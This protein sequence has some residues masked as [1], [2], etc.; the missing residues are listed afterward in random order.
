MSQEGKRLNRNPLYYISEAKIEERLIRLLQKAS[1][2]QSTQVNGPLIAVETTKVSQELS[3]LGI[4][5]VFNK[6]ENKRR[7][8][9]Y[10]LIL[11]PPKDCKIEVPLVNA[12]KSMDTI[13]VISIPSDD[14]TLK[15][16]MAIKQIAS[17]RDAAKA[18]SCHITTT[19][20]LVKHSEFQNSIDKANSSITAKSDGYITELIPVKNHDGGEHVAET[21]TLSAT[22]KD[23]S[24]LVPENEIVPIIS[25]K[26]SPSIHINN[27]IQDVAA[28]EKAS[29][30]KTEFINVMAKESTSNDPNDSVA[31]HVSPINIYAGQMVTTNARSIVE[32]TVNKATLLDDMNSN[33]EIDSGCSIKKSVDSILSKIA[34]FTTKN[35]DLLRGKSPT[36][37]CIAKQPS[38]ITDSDSSQN[39]NEI[40]VEKKESNCIAAKEVS[41]HSHSDRENTVKKKE[42]GP[43]V[44]KE[45]SIHERIGRHVKD[46]FGVKKSVNINAPKATPART[47]SDITVTKYFPINRSESGSCV[48]RRK[49]PLLP[50]ETRNDS[51]ETELNLISRSDSSCITVKA[52][53]LRAIILEKRN[54][55]TGNSVI[56]DTSEATNVDLVKEL[57]FRDKIQALVEDENVMDIMLYKPTSSTKK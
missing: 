7:T 20:A 45:T 54:E 25:R 50:E 1:T 17:D 35:E 2:T 33:K 14:R 49:N 5:L 57:S 28:E 31:E 40:Y 51:N 29:T 30:V 26:S 55:D 13:N 44:A 43:I 48:A 10:N 16:Y 18:T 3:P 6:E 21:D 41:S 22:Q 34:N 19:N 46:L 52:K 15:D 32:V 9:P 27:I 53:S 12:Y 11:K 8:D 24:D 38:F 36:E 23:T 39:I 42:L 56:A 47:Q 4:S 37:T